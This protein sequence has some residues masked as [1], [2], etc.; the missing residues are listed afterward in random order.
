M[1]ANGDQYAI[2]K[3]QPQPRLKQA[4]SYENPTSNLSFRAKAQPKPRSPRISPAAPQNIKLTTNRVPHLREAKVGLQNASINEAQPATAGCP[5]HAA[6]MSGLQG[7]SMERSP[8][9]YRED[10]EYSRM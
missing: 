7:V 5:T 1:V 4:R 8:S 10:C 3:Q 6:G 9:S 2:R